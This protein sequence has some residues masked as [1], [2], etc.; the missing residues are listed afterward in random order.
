MSRGRTL[1]ISVFKRWGDAPV[2]SIA[3]SLFARKDQIH[4][5]SDVGYR[6]DPFQHCPNGDEWK[7][8]R[9]SCDPKDSF[10]VYL[11]HYLSVNSSGCSRISQTTHRTLAYANS[12]I[13][14]YK[15][16]GS[17]LHIYLTHIY[18]DNVCTSGD[19]GLASHS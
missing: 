19:R 18:P 2:H 1:L 8:G 5:F 3:A 6:H 15:G 14:L 10:G 12:K 7:K 4:F 17:V 13:F 9:C 16:Q 11:L